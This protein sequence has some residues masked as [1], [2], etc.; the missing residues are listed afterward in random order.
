MEL[1]A[2]EQENNGLK[3]ALPLFCC[4][5][6]S[7]PNVVL[8]SFQIQIDNANKTASVRRLTEEVEFLRS[9]MADLERQVGS[10]L[11]S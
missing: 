9:R 2:I 11:H 5:L 10:R 7:R 8:C 4:F 1:E 3:V 6:F